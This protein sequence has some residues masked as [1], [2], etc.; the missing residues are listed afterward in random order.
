MYGDMNTYLAKS[1]DLGKT[2]TRLKSDE[3]TGFAHKIKEDPINKNLLFL[4]TER[5]MFASIDGG[6]SWFRMKNHIPDYCMVRDI[7]IQPQTNDLV[8][9]TH[10]RGIM[11]I[12]DISPIR[13]LSKEVVN[14][15]VVLFDSKPQP[16]TTGKFGGGGSP[17]SGGWNAGNPDDIE[18]IEYY[19]KDRPTKDVK[20][21]I[22]DASGKL[23][24]SIPGSKRKGINKV[25]WNMRMTPPK[26]ASGGSKMDIAGFIA[27]M[28]LPGTYTV[29]LLVGDKVYSNKLVLVHDGSNKLF[30]EEDRKTQYTA[31]MQLYHM[32]EELA[33]LV[34]K[35]NAEQKNIKE[36]QDSVKRP[37]TKKLLKE[38]NTKLE[39]LRN[40]LLAS[41]H[42]SIFADEKKLRENITDD[43]TAI[44][45][46]ECKPTNLQLDIIQVLNDDI[47]KAEQA[48]DKLY[49][50]YGDKTKQTIKEDKSKK[51]IEP[52]N[53]N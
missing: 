51:V 10:G 2:W 19:M 38:Y 22:Y 48:Y 50:E 37:Q 4:G 31:A 44:C 23:V 33:A 6:N 3:F 25:Y 28:V 36:N 35:I 49:T 11:V 13:S 1:T 20:V 47:K 8:I 27:P 40:T 32:H 24:Q 12:N 39:D 21:E 16:I 9:A 52:R 42:K 7:A 46:L 41:K 17:V 43:Y 29:K 5:G 26:T 34:D 14:N 18:P 45:G 30:S 15:E 53:S